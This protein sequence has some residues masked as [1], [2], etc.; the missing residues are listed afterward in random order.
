VHFL[1]LCRK[2]AELY[3][4]RGTRLNEATGSLPVTKLVESIGAVSRY[5]QTWYKKFF[6]VQELNR[7]QR[8]ESGCNYYYRFDLRVGAK[9]KM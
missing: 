1:P 5:K 3:A 7:R 4:Y 8:R 9:Q 6:K 2:T